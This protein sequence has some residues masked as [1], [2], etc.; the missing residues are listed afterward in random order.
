MT[1]REWEVIKDIYEK[2]TKARDD[3]QHLGQLLEKSS[4][5]NRS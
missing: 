4:M 1:R 3:L 5:E 2:D